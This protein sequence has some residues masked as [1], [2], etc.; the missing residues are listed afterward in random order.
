[1]GDKIMQTLTIKELKI[2][3]GK[4]PDNYLVFLS[5][6]EEGNGYGTIDS[7][8]LDS[9]KDQAVIIYPLHEGLEIEEIMPKEYG[10]QNE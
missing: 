4:Y 8:V 5:R 9:K 1:M 7:E 6:D 10:E 2:L 3:L